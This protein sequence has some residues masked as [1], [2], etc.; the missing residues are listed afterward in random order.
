MSS[1]KLT[2]KNGREIR[3]G[4]IIYNPYDRDEYHEV[5]QDSTGKLFLGDFRSP[6]EK[7]NPSE[8][9]EVAVWRMR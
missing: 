6:L 4:D 8:F 1:E 7:Y 2:D 5:I 3:A 9:W